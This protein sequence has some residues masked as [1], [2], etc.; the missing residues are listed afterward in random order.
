MVVDLRHQLLGYKC[1]RALQPFFRPLTM[2]F[3]NPVSL[4]KLT[5]YSGSMKSAHRQKISPTNGSRWLLYYFCSFHERLCGR[6]FVG[7]YH[8]SRAGFSC[9]TC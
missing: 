4:F 1:G 2:K 9:Y 8:P 3:L 6:L 5:G 7:P